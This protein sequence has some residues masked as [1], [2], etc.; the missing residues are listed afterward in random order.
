MNK[1]LL[2]KLKE[3]LLAVLPV[4]AIVAFANFL[5]EPMPTLNFAAFLV[6]A[7]FLVI[8]MGLYSLGADTA[9]SAIGLHIGNTLTK[10]KK[11]WIIFP[12]V[13]VIGF[14]VT[15][16]EPDL[17]VLSEQV[18]EAIPKTVLLVTI[19]LGVGAFL[20]LA[21]LRTVLRIDLNVALLALYALLFVGALFVDKM[22]V[23][24]AFDSG[25]VTTGPITVPFIMALG[26]GLTA[27][28]GGKNGQESF[29]MIALCS[30]GPILTVVLL[31]IFYHPVVSEGA[32]TPM[33]LAEYGDIWDVFEN[34]AKQFPFYAKEV[35]V[36]LAPIALFFFVFHAFT[37]R[38]GKIR[39][40]SVIVGLAY[41]Y[42]GLSV[43][44][45]AVNVGFMPTG[46]YVGKALAK[47][48][49]GW[50]IVP[51][52]MAI[53]AAIVLAEPAVHVLNEQVEQITAGL[54]KRATMLKVLAVSVS[55]SV[56]L[57]MVRVL[58]GVS[59]WW[60][61]APGYAVALALSFFTP[62]IFTGIAFDSGGVA[63]GPMTTTFLLPFALGA[64]ASLGGNAFT[65]AFGVVA[66]VALTPLVAI[67]LLGVVYKVKL[68][69]KVR[70]TDEIAKQ[71]A[72]EGDEIV[73][74]RAYFSPKRKSALKGGAN[75]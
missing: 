22:F 31:G 51:V 48:G 23:P 75:K 68:N 64:C 73:D 61:V 28:I 21:F 39:L 3:A 10:T 2:G 71:I 57:S 50:V 58:T 8:G 32:A 72:C 66:F 19:A 45:T 7:F 20:M 49:S 29:G 4:T 60:I 74:V 46:S 65:D 9:M 12:V 25:G 11:H 5:T 13:F 18:G 40:G 17:L 54:I 14:I 69:I 43:F 16:A 26:V 63:S 37:S 6:G 38:L 36:A 53:G 41:T 33:A 67:Q 1:I 27:N 30:V 34:F 15:I 52:G 56:G 47:V 35:G 24:L 70:L 42:V 55:I 59:I 62:K 44:L